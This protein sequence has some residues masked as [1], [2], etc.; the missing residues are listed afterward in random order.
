MLFSLNSF[1]L[2]V[3]PSFSS[4]VLFVFR[5]F[6]FVSQTNL[7]NS[8]SSDVL[9]SNASLEPNWRR[10]FHALNSA[11]QSDP[12]NVTA[13]E[14]GNASLAMKDVLPGTITNHSFAHQ[15]AP[16]S[17]CVNSESVSNEIDES[18]VHD[19]KHPP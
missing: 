1:V 4:F 18:R 7:A 16:A 9:R 14:R 19:E 15:Q 8:R 5:S 12:A 11:S 3:F 17:M 6:L 13:Q 10:V 2:F